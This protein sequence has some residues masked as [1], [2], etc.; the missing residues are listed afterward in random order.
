MA[1]IIEEQI[2]IIVSRIAAND[3][4]DITSVINNETVESLKAV[5]QELV[6]PG[7]I[8]EITASE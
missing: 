3:E 5:A 7:A 2:T 8:V 1:Q 6:G 4:N